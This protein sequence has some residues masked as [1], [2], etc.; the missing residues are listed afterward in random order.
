MF[1]LHVSKV[2]AYG[3][4]TCSDLSN[5]I[6]Q[7]SVEQIG[8]SEDIFS[9]QT[10]HLH[11]SLLSEQNRKTKQQSQQLQRSLGPLGTDSAV[12]TPLLLAGKH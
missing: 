10:L 2:G 6:G 4:K 8:E 11:P 5:K 12:R 3:N 1:I 7:C 9:N